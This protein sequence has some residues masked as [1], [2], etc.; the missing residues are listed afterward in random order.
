MLKHGTPY[1]FSKDSLRSR[2][3]WVP[4]R[5]SVPNA[6]AK[7]RAGC[8]K[9]GEESSWEFAA[10]SGISGF[11]AKRFARAPIPASYAG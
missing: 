5:I 11:A 1:F 6:S 2:R 7:S 4:A 3:E 10:R 9:N 8:E